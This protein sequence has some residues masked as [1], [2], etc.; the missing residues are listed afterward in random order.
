LQRD[1]SFIDRL[2]DEEPAILLEGPADPASPRCSARSPIDG[3]LLCSTSMMTACSSSFVKTSV[4]RWHHQSWGRAAARRLV[5]V[6]GVAWFVPMGLALGWALGPFLSEPV[7]T[8]FR[9]MLSFHAAINAIGLVLCGLIALRRL[10]TQH[11]NSQ[12]H[13]PTPIQKDHHVLADPADR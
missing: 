7:V 3:T 12:D 5:T 4:P 6:S 10:A 13:Q 8:T 11:H 2:L 1:D 9:V